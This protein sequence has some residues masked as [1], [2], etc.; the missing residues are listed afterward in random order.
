LDPDEA[1]ALVEQFES[2]VELALR[3]TQ[4]QHKG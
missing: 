4:P 2:G 3:E 1:R